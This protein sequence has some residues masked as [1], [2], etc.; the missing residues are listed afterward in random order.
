M[1]NETYNIEKD[2]YYSLLESQSF[3]FYDLTNA[4]KKAK[5]RRY[6]EGKRE[7]DKSDIYNNNIAGLGTFTY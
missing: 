2:I 6:F 4:K 1:Y 7:F 5:Y 3:L